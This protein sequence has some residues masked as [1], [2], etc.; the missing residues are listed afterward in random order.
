MFIVK[1]R[2]V[3]YTFSI[4]LIT[5][6]LVALFTWGI[7][8]GIDFKGGSVMQFSYPAGRPS[9]DLVKTS[10]N[11]LPFADT[12][13]EL[14]SVGDNAYVIKLRSVTDKER[15]ALQEAV[16]IG[17]STA[18]IVSFNSIG[19]VL[20]QEAAKKSLIAIVLV[21]I[22]IIIFITY[23]FRKVSE[24][25][26]SWKFG[27]FAI[28]ALFHD[29]FIPVGVF[30]VLGHFLGYEVD[31]LF[32]TAMLVVLGFSVHDTI[33]VYDRVRENLKNNLHSKERKTFPEVVGASIRQTIVRSV[34]TSL[35]ALL[36]VVALYFFGPASTQSFALVLIIGIFF[37]TYSSIFIASNLLVTA[38]GKNK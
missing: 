18:E 6:S 14:R 7:T 20:G 8:L 25:V 22:C 33:V 4:T 26:P 36:A 35:S 19:P 12:I 11:Q 3:F 32:V 5:L 37:G 21:L 10:L 28:V 2:K 9:V 15:V 34:N 17:S 13:K 23:A 24:P 27:L 38:E 29:I 16:N 31:T 30:S 1:Y